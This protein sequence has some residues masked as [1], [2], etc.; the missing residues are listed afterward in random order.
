MIL[1][2]VQLHYEDST[3]FFSGEVTTYATRPS[4]F[5]FFAYFYVLSP[6]MRWHLVSTNHEFVDNEND[7]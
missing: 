1:L 3:S 5:H 2:D 4:E 6:E 7:Q